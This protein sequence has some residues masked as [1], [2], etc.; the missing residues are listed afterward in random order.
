M[1]LC[2]KVL[3]DAV[4]RQG[5]GRMKR[6]TKR[7]RTRDL[8]VMSRVGMAELRG[9]VH[10]GSQVVTALEPVF[11]RSELKYSSHAVTDEPSP[12]PPRARGHS[13]APLQLLS[14]YSQRKS[15]WLC[16]RNAR[17]NTDTPMHRS[18]SHTHD[19]LWTGLGQA[20]IATITTGHSGILQQKQLEAGHCGHLLVI[21]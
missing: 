15:Q 21:C 14:Q 11:L 18:F 20:G 1:S 4:K 6:G 7:Q 19:L 16:K 3:K 5:E 9:S 13:A 17:V 8:K 2:Q 10:R 12:W